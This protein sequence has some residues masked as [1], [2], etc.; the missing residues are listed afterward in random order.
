[1]SLRAAKS[2]YDRK[3]LETFD[4]IG[5]YFIDLF[6]NDLFLKAKHAFSTGH[7]KSLTDTY[8]THIIWFMRGIAEKPKSYIEVMKKLLEYYNGVTK[9]ITSTL[10]EL[11]NKILSQFI[12]PE[13]YQ[14]FTNANKEKVLHDTI[15]RAVNQLG[16]ITLEANMLGKIIDDHMNQGNIQML[17]EKMTDIFISLREEYY[18]KFVDEISKTNGN[19]TVSRDQFKKLKAEYAEEIKRRV[20]AESERDRAVQL[21]QVSLK[22]IS[23]LEEALNV[24]SSMSSNISGGLT[25]NP[26]NS[27]PSTPMQKDQTPVRLKSL[28]SPGS[29]SPIR[30]VNLKSPLRP[31]TSGDTTGLKLS[32]L[33]ASGKSNTLRPMK[34]SDPLGVLT[35]GNTVS[36]GNSVSMGNSASNSLTTNILN[37]DTPG[38]VSGVETN[39]PTN[40]PASDDGD[41]NESGESGESSETEDSEELHKRQ[42]KALMDKKKQAARIKKSSPKSKKVSTKSK[43]TDNEFSLGLDDDPGFGN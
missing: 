27:E 39:D 1:M 32:D 25:I 34:D 21:L 11:E 20:T 36:A 40:N 3:A 23:E 6:Y 43:S 10:N 42:K 37:I 38:I 28:R 35:S 12:P 2:K 15:I 19:K 8:R 4:I 30:T 22:K 29:Q 31:M 14:D 17:Q 13:Y 26:T 24:S 18:S 16:E 33:T 7:S 41:S 5:C 9:T